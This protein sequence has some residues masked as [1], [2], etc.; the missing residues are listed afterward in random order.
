MASSDPQSAAALARTLIDILPLF[1]AALQGKQ[2]AQGS[3]GVDTATA[4][5]FRELQGEAEDLLQSR[6]ADDSLMRSMEALRVGASHSSEQDLCK[7]RR[8]ALK[9]VTSSSDC[10]RQAGNTAGLAE[11]MCAL[12]TIQLAR[13]RPAA[14]VDAAS[15]AANIFRKMGDASG[16]VVASGLAMDAHMAKASSL[17]SGKHFRQSHHLK[18]TATEA[19]EDLKKERDKHFRD[20]LREAEGSLGLLLQLKRKRERA[21]LLCKVAEMQI[22]VS[23]LEDA[24]ESAMT[25]RDLYHD[26]HD[27]QGEKAALLVEMDAHIAC[28]DGSEALDVAKEI[29][30]VFRKAKDKRGEADGMLIMMN[31]YSMMGQV[32]EMTKLAKDVRSLCQSIN[33]KKMEGQLVES[34]MKAHI[35]KDDVEVALSQAREAAELYRRAGDKSGEARALHA[36]G[37]LELD[38]F[39]KRVESDLKQFKKMG[40]TQ[41]HFKEVDINAYEES[42]G[43]VRKAVELFEEV[44]DVQG[45]AQAKQTLQSSDQKA[46]M[47][48]DPNETK[49]IFKDGVC[50]SQVRIWNPSLSADDAVNPAV[51]DMRT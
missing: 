37:C 40:C 30:K 2:N 11:A 32:D 18:M 3:K 48:N 43:L 24:K 41:Q 10:F 14:S 34:L 21:D 22:A 47:M 16:E 17:G 5:R 39:F 12:A 46:A 51:A 31:V 44:E 9:A 1:G 29:T 4:K 19:Q 50:V 45:Q 15:D 28:R 8:K 6:R 42:L 13:N 27:Q 33:D 25:A 49:Q 36:R 20:A 38:A 23:D 26:L 7:S 35:D